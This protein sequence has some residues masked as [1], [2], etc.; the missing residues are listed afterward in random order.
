[1]ETTLQKILPPLQILSLLVSC[2]LNHKIS[3]YLEN[4]AEISRQAV[5]ML[6]SQG[7]LFYVLLVSQKCN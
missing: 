6:A 5:R 3:G 7:D 1:M 2:D 4:E